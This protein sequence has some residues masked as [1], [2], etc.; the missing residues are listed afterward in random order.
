MWREQTELIQ[1]VSCGENK[2][3]S[4]IMLPRALE[5]NRGRLDTRGRIELDTH[6]MR[7]KSI[8]PGLLK[9]TLT[10]LPTT[11]SRLY[12]DIRNRA[13]ILLLLLIIRALL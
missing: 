2:Q 12:R 11:H 9:D 5:R 7:D 13:V 4:G 6:T 8:E 3:H 1:N 10:D